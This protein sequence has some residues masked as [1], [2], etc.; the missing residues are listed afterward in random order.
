MLNQTVFLLCSLDGFFVPALPHAVMSQ[1]TPSAVLS[2][3]MGTHYARSVA[4]R[5]GVSSDDLT[6]SLAGTRYTVRRGCSA[7][8]KW[9]ICRGLKR[10]RPDEAT[11][12]MTRPPPS[13][14]ASLSVQRTVTAK[15][16]SRR[17]QTSN[18][19]RRENTCVGKQTV[20]ACC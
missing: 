18:H 4:R 11:R 19:S 2:C 13:S 5:D 8:D 1:R 10:P 14:T 12:G 9:S 15:T 20:N 16:T 17:I 7:A 3:Y 6:A